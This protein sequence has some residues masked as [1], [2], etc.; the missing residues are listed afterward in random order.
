VDARLCRIVQTSE[1][2]SKSEAAKDLASWAHTLS[3]HFGAPTEQTED[4]AVWTLD[5]QSISL[6]SDHDKTSS[7]YVTG[8]MYEAFEVEG[9]LAGQPEFP[10]AMSGFEFG[11]TRGD[12][13]QLCKRQAGLFVD[14][15]EAAARGF[16]CMSLKGD[17]P[18]A[19][20][21]IGGLYCDGR[22]CELSLVLSES[23]RR[24]LLFM[25]DKYGDTPGYAKENPKCGTDAKRYF[26]RWSRDEELLGLVRLED[27]CS[28]I[29]YYDNAAGWRLRTEQEQEHKR[30][31]TH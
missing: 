14:I 2:V 7:Q 1:P 15:T 18:L 23:S 10:T 25:S 11:M 6:F 19:F 24:A 5:R 17:S 26:W 8:V 3:A 20:T 16:V 21:G 12:A 31:Q 28:P 4:D 29:V 13:K 22:V 9:A 30:N 27:D